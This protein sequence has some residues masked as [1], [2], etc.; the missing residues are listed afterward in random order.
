MLAEFETI[1]NFWVGAPTLTPLV[2]RAFKESFLQWQPF[3]NDE[4]GEIER[5]ENHNFGAAFEVR[6]AESSAE[7]LQAIEDALGRER[8]FENCAES[9][10]ASSEDYESK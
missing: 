5:R 8:I 9:S 7:T 4:A 1:R 2:A 10:A 3:A 6:Y